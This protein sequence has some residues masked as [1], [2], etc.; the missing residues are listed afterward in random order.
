[1]ISIVCIDR[2]SLLIIFLLLT[3][4]VLCEHHATIRRH[5][6]WLLG[7]ILSVDLDSP[8]N[9]SQSPI[10]RDSGV[11]KRVIVQSHYQVHNP[12]AEVSSHLKKNFE[13]SL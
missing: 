2:C 4:T 11:W 9:Q 1:M 6:F 3:S 13:V 7:K 8:V 12:T 10:C 5:V